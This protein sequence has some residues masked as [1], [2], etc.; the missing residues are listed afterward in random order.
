MISAEASA[1]SDFLRMRRRKKN[2]ASVT[3]PDKGITTT[4]PFR[5]SC[6]SERPETKVEAKRTTASKKLVTH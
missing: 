1:A 4:E 2:C 6:G 3:S 5:I